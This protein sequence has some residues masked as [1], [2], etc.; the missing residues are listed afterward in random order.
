MSLL[1]VEPGESD[2]K[3]RLRGTRSRSTWL[4]G[5]LFLLLA[6]SSGRT[7]AEVRES[8]AKFGFS[9]DP[10]D[11]VLL[12]TYSGGLSGAHPVYELYGDGRLEYRYES[13]DGKI[14]EKYDTRIQFGEM[15]E[16]IQD[17]INHGLIESST[18]DILAKIKSRNARG[19]IPYVTD[20][21]VTILEV[22]L[23]SYVRD[24]QEIGPIH[25]Q[26]TIES[27]AHLYRMYPEILELEGLFKIANRLR[28]LRRYSRGGGI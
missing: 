14:L 4:A 20:S 5:L 6:V 19:S 27:S 13:I 15:R 23:T 9:T 26:I 10:T 1:N 25:R 7:K 16:I 17:L 21:A 2:V 22:N 18:S 12:L 11:L 28:E 24:N 3:T 8:Q